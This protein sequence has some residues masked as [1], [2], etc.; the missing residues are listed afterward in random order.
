MSV[1]KSDIIC[2]SEAYL[3]SSADD[4]S[5]EIF[6]YYLIHFDHPSNKKAWWYLHFLEKLPSP[7]KLT[8]HEH[9]LFLKKK[10]Q[11]NTNN[12]R[13]TYMHDE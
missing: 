4:E 6:G 9:F 13:N 8:L 10:L 12:N 3:D 2:L 11:Y 7:E 5:L 1:H